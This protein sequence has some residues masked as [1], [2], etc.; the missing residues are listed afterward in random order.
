MQSL[1]VGAVR[2]PPILAAIAACERLAA[3]A[4]GEHFAAMTSNLRAVGDKGEA[5]VTVL[6]DTGATKSFIRRSVAEKISTITKLPEPIVFYLANGTSKITVKD[7][8]IVTIGQGAKSIIDTF[9]VMDEQLE[10]VILGEG[11]MRRFALKI[12]MERGQVY[13]EI[14]QEGNMKEFWKKICAALSIAGKEDA[15]EDQ[16]IALLKENVGARRDAPVLIATPK[17]LAVLDLKAD[18]TEDQVRGAILALKSPGDTVP[19]AKVAELEADLHQH[20]IIAAVASARA[21]GKLTLAEEPT[22]LKDL[23]EGDETL[24]AFAVFIER[25]GKVVPIDV[26]LPDKK[27]DI[28]AAAIDD[29]QRAINRQMGVTDEVFKKHNVAAS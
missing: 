1:N 25:R 27:I 15:T 8:A 10:D 18:A 6:F 2:E 14:K 12:D 22:W 3:V 17:I 29:T 5:D 20:K 11:T 19:A 16:A 26:R 9:L 13:A 23:K 4:A 24:A 21:I 28:A 7:I